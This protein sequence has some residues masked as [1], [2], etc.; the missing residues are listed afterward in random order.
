MTTVPAHP[1]APPS[2]SGTQITVDTA[3]KQPTRINRMVSD[4]TLQKFLID[5]IFGYNG[6]VSGGAVVYDVAAQN[7]LYTSTDRPVEQI[8]PGGE[9]PIVTS[10]RFAPKV[11]A[12]GKYGA[13]VFIT[14]EAKDRNDEVK[15]Q[16][17]IRQLA[18]T[19]V[20][21]HNT[22]AIASL[23]AAISTYSRS[24]ASISWA[25]VVTA[26]S[27]ASSAEEWPLKTFADARVLNE[28]DEMGIEFN[29]VILNPQEY[30]VLVTTYGVAGLQAIMDQL[31]FTIEVSNRQTAGKAKFLARGQVGGYN[32]EQPLQTVTYR[33]EGTDRTWVKSSV[34]PVSYVDNPFAV[35]EYTGL[36]A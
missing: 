19:L 7:E 26:G 8:A 24:G 36:A 31:G 30:G 4:L 13:K 23:D 18:N 25:D 9:Y 28:T 32:L 21:K 1:L 15:F 29:T 10:D 11:A 5:K 27:S 34:R 20:K 35:F 6:S 17:E 12:V 33:E 22:L 16:N 3:L 14:D 2:V